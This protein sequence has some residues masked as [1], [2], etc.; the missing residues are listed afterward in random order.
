MTEKF[1]VL[2]SMPPGAEGRVE[3]WQ[4][5]EDGLG[6]R[7]TFPTYEEARVWA[8]ETAQRIGADV[9]TRRWVTWKWEEDEA[10]RPISLLPKTF[11]RGA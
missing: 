1:L 9:V 2:V 3:F 8:I 6:D 4:C 11:S 7:Q 5:G 10:G